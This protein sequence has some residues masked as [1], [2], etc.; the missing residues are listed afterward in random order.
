MERILDLEVL[1]HFYLIIFYLRYSVLICKMGI[2]ISI[3]F[4]YGLM[5]KVKTCVNS[6]L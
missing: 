4:L 1:Y 2:I 6:C 5:V 3:I